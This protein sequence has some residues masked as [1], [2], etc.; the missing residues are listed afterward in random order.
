MIQI[1]SVQDTKIWSRNKRKKKL[2]FLT[3]PNWKE[4]TLGVWWI[5]ATEFG[6]IKLLHILTARVVKVTYSIFSAAS[7]AWTYSV[8]CWPEALYHKGAVRHVGAFLHYRDA[9]SW[10]QQGQ[11]TVAMMNAKPITYSCVV[12][13][14]WELMTSPWWESTKRMQPPVTDNEVMQT[15]MS[16]KILKQTE[17]WQ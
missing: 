5:A 13:G 16:K 10:H 9:R 7:P 4:N 15:K 6:K 8:S 11:D 17:P 3:L 14:L 12:W 2:L 1:I